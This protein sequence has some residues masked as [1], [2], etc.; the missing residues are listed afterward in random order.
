MSPL[1]LFVEALSSIVREA[2][3]IAPMAAGIAWGVASVF[4]LVAVARGFES[5]QR[6]QLEALGEDF[7]LLRVNRASNSPQARLRNDTFLRLEG[8]DLAVAEASSPS[9]AALSPKANNWFILGYRGRNETRLT[10]VG[11]EPD[12]ADIVNL[13]LLPGSRWIDQNDLEQELPVC[14]IGA[15]AR[16]DLFGDDPWLGQELRLVFTRG[17]GEDSISR[18]LTVIGALQDNEL[19]GDEVYTSHRRSV[20]L[21]FSTWERMSP[22]GF[23]FF[24]M[25]PRTPA[26]KHQALA[27]LRA[28]IANRRGFDPLNPN[29]VLPYFDGISQG[30]RLDA[31]FGGLRVFLIAVGALILLLGAVGVANVVL[32]SV[33]ARTYEFGL[34]RA[35]GCKRRWIFAQVFL[36]A[37]LVCV[38]SGAAG[39][40]LG[41][42]GVAAMGEMDLPEGF[43]APRAELD[44]A[45]LPGALLLLVSLAAAAWPAARAARGSVVNALHGGGL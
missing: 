11:V 38:V 21:P 19:A 10:A 20:L 18:K 25:R 8:D 23:Q 30:Q 7:L 4:V 12:Y 16:E 1:V 45:L 43:A 29:S 5:T 39:F 13:P 32:M 6:Q 41:A 9:L 14:V 22:R 42:G 15:R 28:A 35:L 34:R 24:V 2:R 40:L 37:G 33:T 36:E 44:G 3:R 26:L 31:V 17:A 27:E